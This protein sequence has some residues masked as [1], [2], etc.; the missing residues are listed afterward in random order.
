MLHQVVSDG[1]GGGS[2]GGGGG[3]GCVGGIDEGGGGS[4]DGRGGGRREGNCVSSWP[5]TPANPR[6]LLSVWRKQDNDSMIL[7]TNIHSW[8]QNIRKRSIN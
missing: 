1:G 4:G 2:G 8:E 3:V 5:G 7:N 6:Q